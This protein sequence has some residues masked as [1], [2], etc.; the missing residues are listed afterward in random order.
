[1]RCSRRSASRVGGRSRDGGSKN[2]RFIC[3]TAPSIVCIVSLPCPLPTSSSSKAVRAR[4][5]RERTVS[6][7]NPKS[8]C[9]VLVAESRPGAECKHVLLTAGKF[10]ARSSMARPINASSSI[11]SSA[12]SAKLGSDLGC[13]T[14]PECGRVTTLG[15]TSVVRTTLL[16][17]PRSH[18]SSFTTRKPLVE[19]PPRLKIDDRHEILGR[20]PISTLRKQ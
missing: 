8:D 6:D 2:S 17:T 5:R 20:R 9:G 14:A 4:E 13:G 16:A 19:P 1:M 7:R 3:S 12:S 11:R 10:C 15:P 18:G